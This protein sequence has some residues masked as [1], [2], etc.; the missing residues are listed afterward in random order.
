MAMVSSGALTALLATACISLGCLTRTPAWAVSAMKGVH[1]G[2][3]T[4]K[5]NTLILI[6]KII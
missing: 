1:L 6:K 4:N 2:G 5:K 3:K